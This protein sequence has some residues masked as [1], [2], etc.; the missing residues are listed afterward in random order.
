MLAVGVAERVAEGNKATCL[1]IRRVLIDTEQGR[2]KHAKRVERNDVSDGFR[3]KLEFNCK[4]GKISTK[5]KRYQ[6]LVVDSATFSSPK[7]RASQSDKFSQ[8]QLNK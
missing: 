4:A 2:V 8:A 1:I 6:R 3:S 7:R 5:Q